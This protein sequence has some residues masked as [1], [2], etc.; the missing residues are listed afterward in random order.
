MSSPG[1]LGEERIICARVIER[2]KGEF[3]RVARLEAIL[4]EQEPLS[5]DSGFQEQIV[6]PSQTDIVVILI[7]SRLGYRLS[8]KFKSDGDA[9]APTG[10]IFEFRDALDGRR[11]SAAKT[12][13][14]MVY[15]KTAEPPKPSISD[16]SAYLKTLEDYER[17]EAFFN[18]KYFKD[19]ENDGAFTG[20]YHTFKRG[21]EF[22]ENFE[23]H[24][25]AMIIRRLGEQTGPPRDHWK[26]G[27]PFRGLESF[28]FEHRELFAGRAR[29]SLEVRDALRRQATAGRAF[30]LVMGMSG[31]GKSSL[32]RA[33]VLPDLVQPGVIEGVGLWR[34]VVLR[35]SETQGDIFRGLADALLTGNREQ[36]IGLPELDEDGAGAA[37]LDQRL[38]ENPAAVSLVVEGALR[39]AAD[40]ERV[41]Q[42][43]RLQGIRREREAAGQNDEVVEI[44]KALAGLK[45]PQARLALV[46]DQMEEIFTDVRFDDATRNAFFA[47]LSALSRGGRSWILAT[48]RSDFFSRCEAYPDLVSLKEGD[49]TYH[50]LAPNEAE[51]SQMIRHPARLAGLEYE[52]EPRTKEAL[53]DVLLVAATREPGALPLLQFTLDELYKRA[54]AAGRVQL[55]HADYQAL[56]GLEGALARRA[57]EVFTE[58]SARDS[59]ANEALPIVFGALVRVSPG[60]EGGGQAVGG[61]APLDRFAATAG[62][63]ELVSALVEARLLVSHRGI[64]RVA[65]EAL[66]QHWE[67]LRDWIAANTE[68]LVTRARISGAAER[69]LAEQRSQ[70]LLLP[71]GKPLVEAEEALARRRDDLSA[72]EAEFIEASTQA[73]RSDEIAAAARRKNVLLAI[74]SAAVLALAFAILS[75]VQYR[76]ADAAAKR[77]TFA[78]NEAEK[79]IEFMGVD[80]RKKLAPIG[81]LE[82]LD[83][84]SQRVRAYY[85][86]FTAQADQQDP[87]IRSRQSTAL[88]NEGEILRARGD[89]TGALKSFREA[90]AIRADLLASN[91]SV[92][93][94]I[95][96]LAA[97]EDYIADV[98]RAN[99]DS[100]GAIRLYQAGLSRRSA[101]AAQYPT[102][103]A[104][105]RE[106][107]SSHTNL[108]AAFTTKGDLPAAL[109][110]YR[111]ALA[112]DT[113]RAK[114]NPAN[115]EW[116]HDFW[117]SQMNVA[118]T[119]LAQNDLAGALTAFGEALGLIRQLIAADPKN[120]YWQRDLAVA[121]E[122]EGDVLS[123]RG[124][125]ANS[126]AR[127]RDALIIH[128]KLASQDPTN[129]DWQR[130]LFVC[131]VRVGETL[132]AREDASGALREFS[133]ALAVQQHLLDLD[134]D[135]ATWQRNFGVAHEKVGAALLA[136]QDYAGA[137]MSFQ[138]SLNIRRKVA[139][140]DP[141]N[142]DS[143][144][145][146]FVC[147]TL[148]GDALLGQKNSEAALTN[149]RAAIVM[150]RQLVAQDATNAIWQR[151]LAETEDKVGQILETRSSVTDA[152]EAYRP[153]LAIYEKLSA[154]NQA[155]PGLRGLVAV[156]SFHL[157]RALAK[158]AP[159]DI[160]GARAALD[161]SRKVFAELK[162]A[163][164]ILPKE[165]RLATEEL[166]LAWK[167]LPK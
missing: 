81:R 76:R 14:L 162:S 35:P 68:F 82:L 66:L 40:A 61:G 100:A 111:E 46:I 98:L 74:S 139:V 117:T 52:T 55:T 26:G 143:R 93:V 77:A 9:E 114:T 166:D 20:A 4:W 112:I 11:R 25:R 44:D 164:A 62:A 110:S 95:A 3:S 154:E 144:Y 94:R 67:R 131:H 43:E 138:N 80:L 53:S 137:L 33:G 157:G 70:D 146:E 16:R 50:L 108:G 65:H 167:S 127:N 152:I 101:L 31:G 86:S 75:L 155:N 158:T 37:T 147:L 116:Q 149:Y 88:I 96:A 39:Q 71:K 92:A 8:S 1:D 42:R 84:A 136:Q 91:P 163:G 49:G 118:D 140:R 120:A 130:D 97:V 141:A 85:N 153:A 156:V 161:R 125:Q 19:A 122:R 89:L 150:D 28:L 72:T 2:L 106:I 134:P 124:D 24:I 15:R 38:R 57:E 6:L 148:V 21:S 58:F 23:R 60:G 7:W 129:T 18:S 145:E 73:R 32:V 121:L 10:T 13:D 113:A 119:M 27:S 142:A 87:D 105:A 17:V 54:E 29:A 22:S 104:W 48:L 109:N 135:N 83:S 115:L 79:L 165:Q 51:I 56:A 123:A 63:T 64:V 102:E 5:A 59:R 90:Q 45:P 126:L 47:A 133:D 69:W 159:P 128:R 12:P 36:G 99:G 34:R 41:V 30:V 160:V 151:D 103:S 132:L 107:A 78:R